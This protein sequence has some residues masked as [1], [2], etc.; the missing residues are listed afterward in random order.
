VSVLRYESPLS[1]GQLKTCPFDTYPM[2]E[3]KIES[4]L[5]ADC[6]NTTT[7]VVLIEA[8][9]GQHRLVTTGQAPSTHGLPWQDITLGIQ[10]AIRQIEKKKGRTLLAPGGWLITPRNVSR[11]GADV[12]V[13]V[14][15]AGPPLSIALAGLMQD[16]TLT[17]ARRA[18]ATTYTLITTELSLDSEGSSRRR[19]VEAQVQALQAEA[20]EVILIVGGTDGGAE[21]P[22][23]E[24][25]NVISMALQVLKDGEKP[26]VLFAGNIEV[27]PQVAEILGSVA[28]LKVVDN[29]R[30]TL[31]TENLAA[32]QVELE[33]L[34]LQRKMSRLPGFDKL[35]NWTRFPPAPASKSFEKAIAYIGQHNNL[36]VLGVNLGSGATMVSSQ[37]QGH[38]S[39][40]IRS[41]AGI[42]HSLASL[43]KLVPL[44]RFHRW[45]PFELER[46][47]LHNQLL[48]KCL[49][50]AT[51]P[52]TYEALMVECAAA[53]EA[54]RLT[55]EQARA[56]WPLQQSSGRRDIQWNLM[57]G[58]GRILTQ[59][60]HFN[61]AAMMM[62]D[63]IEPWGVT[64]LAL[65]VNGIVNML[66]SIAV[67][68]PVAA[69]EV[70]AH[71]AFLNLGTVVAP[72]GHGQ[73]GQPALNV[74]VDYAGGDR[75]EVEVPYGSIKMVDLHPGEKAT[76]EIRP[77]RHFDVG[78]GQPGRGAL[79]D[80]EGGIL[81]IIIDARGRP[82]R[83]PKDD[84]LR[85]ALLRQWLEELGIRHAASGHND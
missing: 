67:V 44:E 45:L 65:D 30:P 52:T 69:V 38:Y 73:P 15:S 4:I 27:R 12:F 25:A 83:L 48:N 51:I 59:A 50:P 58:A 84:V 63:A 23:I 2:A 42:G 5:A 20:P 72:A 35:K 60:P 47:E 13:V 57:I 79:A 8:S 28:N 78:L 17:S 11:Q 64:S 34:Y 49:R 70:T 41:N 81:G 62:L 9:D 7:T 18:V 36:N 6:G 80:V 74:K 24:M 16:I 31:D 56:G 1:S 26:N 29:V 54:L 61:H 76:L 21:R 3:S 71:N 85:Q 22:V 53:R 66:G 55:V 32:T 10:E 46:E 75:I 43:L 77:T 19:S 39:S 68:H 37:A 40:T 82:L 14:S 33:N